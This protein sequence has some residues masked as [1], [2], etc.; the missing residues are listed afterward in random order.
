MK[1]DGKRDKDIAALE[2][3]MKALDT[4]TSRK[5]LCANLAFLVDHYAHN[6][7]QHLPEHLKPVAK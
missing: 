5:M 6:P 7:S 1:T 4:S 2:K 3:C